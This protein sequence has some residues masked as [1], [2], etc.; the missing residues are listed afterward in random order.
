MV[1]LADCK[2]RR[3]LVYFYPA[4]ST[5]GCTKQACDF[6][7]SPAELNGASLDIVGLAALTSIEIRCRSSDVA[8]YCGAA[9]RYGPFL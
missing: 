8:P 7:D 3:A 6:R 4:A 9:S 5:P 1:S 2:G